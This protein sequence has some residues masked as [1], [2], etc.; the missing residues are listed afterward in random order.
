MTP[1]HATVVEGEQ[2]EETSCSV[3]G[4]E[5]TRLPPGPQ[6]FLS[7]YLC[8][9]VSIRLL[10]FRCELKIVLFFGCLNLS[11]SSLSDCCLPTAVC[12]RPPLPYNFILSLESVI[13]Y[14][15]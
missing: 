12:L 6:L 5:S 14:C 3:A 7:P 2:Q 11:P 8:E 15:K 1:T 10:D 13:S 9:T 4:W